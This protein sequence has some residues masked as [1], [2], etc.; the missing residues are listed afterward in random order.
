MPAFPRPVN[1]LTQT[2]SSSLLGTWWTDR[3]PLGGVLVPINAIAATACPDNL[4]GTVVALSLCIRV[5]GG[6]IG[7]TIYY[8]IFATKLKTALPTYI[9]KA[10]IGAGLPASDVTVFIETLLGA[11]T[12][13]TTVPGV[14]SAVIAAATR[15]TQEAY[16]YGLKYVWLTSIAFGVVA[17]IACIFLPS[18]QRFLTDRIAAHIKH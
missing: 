12:K 11:P 7:Y 2:C 18:N 10:A 6:S 1:V 15:A 3:Y 13:I 4:I 9:A 5:V 8:N 17:I 16:A 14:T